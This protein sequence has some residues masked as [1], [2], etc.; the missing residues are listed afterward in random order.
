MNKH[1]QGVNWV[2][3]EG[4]T[5]NDDIPVESPIVLKWIR[6][7]CPGQRV[8]IRA[9]PDVS[10]ETLDFLNDSNEIE[11]LDRLINGFYQLNDGK[12]CVFVFAWTDHC[13]YG[14]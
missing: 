2:E 11:V 1:T 3:I 6:L 9:N 5:K 12:V 8:R 4:P 14:M 7:Q 10:A 13:N